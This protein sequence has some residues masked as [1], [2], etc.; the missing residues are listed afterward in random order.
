MLCGRASS[1]L[2]S[3]VLLL[4]LVRA[5]VL[6]N[7]TLSGYINID[8]TDSHHDAKLF[9][10]LY[11]VQQPVA[12]TRNIPVLLWLQARTRPRSW[13]FHNM[14]QNSML[15]IISLNKSYLHGAKKNRG[16]PAARRCLVACTS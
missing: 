1:T 8:D 16:V 5:T 4:P 14:T 13:A 3:L 9:Y 12:N 7:V 11:E 10:A 2:L 6:P 15:P